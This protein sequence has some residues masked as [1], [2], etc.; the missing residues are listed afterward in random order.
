MMTHLPSHDITNRKNNSAQ[1][2]TLR[3]SLGLTLQWVADAANVKLRTAQ[4]WEAGRM[5]VPKDIIEKLMEVELNLQLFVTE[6]INGYVIKF[7]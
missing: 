4:Y 5:S 1:L 3:E 2:K 6:A 7:L